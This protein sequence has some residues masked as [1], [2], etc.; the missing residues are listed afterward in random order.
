MKN[1][2]DLKSIAYSDYVEKDIS[3]EMIFTNLVDTDMLYGHRNDPKGYGMAIEEID[4]YLPA[5]IEAMTEDD[6][7]IITADHG[8]DPCVEGTDH[9]REKVPVL[10]Y[11][12][13][14]A[15][16]NLGTLIGFDHVADF[17][18]DWIF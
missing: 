10:V 8:C 17:V 5:I 6:L 3:Y 4:T 2:L 11:D 13:K 14:E 12:K 9:T 1:E 15:G 18:R 7:L 16:E